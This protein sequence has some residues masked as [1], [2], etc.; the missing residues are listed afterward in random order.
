MPV[1]TFRCP[2][3]SADLKVRDDQ[4]TAAPVNCPDCR[5]P[6]VIT[7]DEFGHVTATTP[8]PQAGPAKTAKGSKSSAPSKPAGVP[9][10]K[11]APAPIVREE[12]VHATES[13]AS[14]GGMSRNSILILTGSVAGLVAILV[15]G[16][17]FWPRGGHTA[18]DDVKPAESAAKADP[19]TASGDK[20]KAHVAA[21]TPNQTAA[22]KVE[23][24][25]T[26]SGRLMALGQRI[27]EYRVKKGHYPSAV[28]GRD[29][30]P[31]PER[32][33]WLAELVATVLLPDHPAPSWTDSWRSPHN[34][35]FVRQRI[36]EFLN[37]S[38]DR[39]TG[40]ENYP[41][42][43]FA[44]VS[45]VGADAADLPI[46]HPRAGI[47]GN[48]RNTRMQDIRDGA[49]NTLMVVGVT[50]ELGSWAA[51][52]TPTMRALTREP[53]INGPDGIGT[54]SPDRMLVLKADGSVQEFSAKTDPR[55]LRRMAAMAD[56]LPL[57]PK[58]PGEPGEQSPQPPVPEH[59][60]AAAKPTP[61]TPSAPVR[62]VADAKPAPPP[63]KP[64]PPVAASQPAGKK[65]TVPVPVIKPD[66]T[67]TLAQRVV[68]YEQIKPVPL[69]EVLNVLEELTAAPI[70]GDRQEIPD[71]DDLLQTPVSLTLDNTTVAAILEAVLAPAKLT[72]Q[73]QADAIQLHR[74]GPVS[75]RAGSP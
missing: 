60:A 1:I 71:L 67:A 9:A 11:S 69:R 4:I 18:A 42:T 47:F 16:V 25:P 15:A 74:L 72:Y 68:H 37:P 41:A 40:A 46:N 17:F 49:S 43:H 54:G 26:V 31:P 2:H 27:I 5:Q 30:L 20:G 65:P 33:S 21:P 59:L 6:I 53:Y 63:G 24:S 8:A 52:G 57:D 55:I 7:R 61:P 70:R 13:P 58:V 48:N 32:L 36:P 75:G 22:N 3:C 12:S 64:Q 28:P 73:V 34:E 10:T 66:L 51:S 45:G 56:G 38:V 39:L 19:A 35:R 23:A 50:G 14:T 29:G 62:N 44:G